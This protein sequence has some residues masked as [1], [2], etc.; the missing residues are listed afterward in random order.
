MLQQAS[1]VFPEEPVRTGSEWTNSVKV[2]NPAVGDLSVRTRYRVEGTEK[3]GRRS[4]VRLGV[5]SDT[6]LSGDVPLID[7]LNQM[8][9]DGGLNVKVAW[10]L[11]EAK[12]EGTMWIDRKTGLVAEMASTGSVDMDISVAMDEGPV[13]LKM[14]MVQQ[15]RMELVD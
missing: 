6:S 2:R 3:R 14:T 5:G 7:Q 10:E 1:A 13:A 9:D 4:C 8:F 15:I 11:R 12:G